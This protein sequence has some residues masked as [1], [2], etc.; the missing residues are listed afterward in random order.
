LVL[1][2]KPSLC[3]YAS[4]QYAINKRNA[5]RKESKMNLSTT[6]LSIISTAERLREI[7]N[8]I[9]K[10]FHSHSRL[11]NFVSFFFEK[12][13]ENSESLICMANR[14]TH[15][16]LKTTARTIL[17]KS[18]EMQEQIKSNMDP[19]TSPNSSSSAT[20]SNLQLT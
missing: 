8:S 6:F 7:L 1:K 5:K 10:I 15:T 16:A 17:F 11:K 3:S 19:A 12:K 14:C 2:K 9:L 20:S 4:N 18:G 13:R